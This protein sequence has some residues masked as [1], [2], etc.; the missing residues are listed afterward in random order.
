MIRSTPKLLYFFWIMAICVLTI[1]I[2][3]SSSADIDAI[4][5]PYF[6]ILP[7][8]IV[9]MIVD[10]LDNKSALNFRATS[11]SL[12][13]Y[14]EMSHL[15]LNTSITP[16]TIQSFKAQIKRTNKNKRPP[17]RAIKILRHVAQ[18]YLSIPSTQLTKP[19]AP[20]LLNRMI[21]EDITFDRAFIKSILSLSSLIELTIKGT[22]KTGKFL[23]E[24]G[25]LRELRRLT[26]EESDATG[27]DLVPIRNC[28]T[29]IHLTLNQHALGK[30]DPHWLEAL[31]NL[32]H[33]SVKQNS[34]GRH[35][36]IVGKLTELETLDISSN[37]L[38]DA[39][40]KQLINLKKLRTLLLE[41]NDHI[42]LKGL[43][44]LRDLP[45]TTLFL[46]SRNFRSEDLALITNAF[47]HLEHLHLGMITIAKTHLD[48]AKEIKPK[49]KISLFL[50]T[51]S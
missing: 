28:T 46:N 6:S 27:V 42:T 50:G 23:K 8:D 1:N 30:N 36:S 16:N 29:L 13:K 37:E 15:Q 20:T 49:M 32:R 2:S 12:A 11:K 22:R 47:A 48:K 35:L 4:P 14:V 41:N 7:R 25:A 38:K 18:T 51:I 40:L 9:I 26:I 3:K 24:I 45:I 44:E 33:L 34:L 5:T 17:T 43:L 31:V 10:E 19:S 21:L 39:N